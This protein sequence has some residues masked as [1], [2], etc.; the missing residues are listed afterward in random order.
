MHKHTQNTHTHILMSSSCNAV[1]HLII[2]IWSIEY[3][4]EAQAYSEV[5][6]IFTAEDGKQYGS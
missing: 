1:M 2:L 4:F 5:F 6:I 3:D